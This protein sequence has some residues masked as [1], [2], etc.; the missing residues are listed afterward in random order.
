MN[1]KTLL[2]VGMGVI[3]FIVLW[4]LIIQ[5]STY[6]MHVEIL[7]TIASYTSKEELLRNESILND[8]ILNQERAINLWKETIINQGGLSIIFA[9]IIV[10]AQL[11]FKEVQKEQ[12]D[13][14]ISKKL[15]EN[16]S[17]YKDL[18]NK[19]ITLLNLAGNSI[20]P[21]ESVGDDHLY[22]AIINQL[23]YLSQI[24]GVDKI[25]LDDFKFRVGQ[26]LSSHILKGKII[27]KLKEAK[28]LDKETL[29]A[30]VLQ[31]DLLKIILYTHKI[32]GFDRYTYGGEFIAYFEALDDSDLKTNLKLLRN[33]EVYKLAMSDFESAKDKVYSIVKIVGYLISEGDEKRAVDFV[34]HTFPPYVE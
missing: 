7:N 21:F 8:F 32:K 27:P 5:L 26:N 13:E 9:V 11:F 10:I 1:Q 4:T 25:M 31:D 19:F 16:Q 14:I 12:V 2:K 24:T 20:S 33:G 28:S 23:F 34:H 3:I 22:Y 29:R 15:S 30:S 18:E 17:Y 6:I